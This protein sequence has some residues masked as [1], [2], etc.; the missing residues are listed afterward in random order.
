MVLLSLG[1]QALIALLQTGCTSTAGD[2][3]HPAAPDLSWLLYG[4]ESVMRLPAD[5][6]GAYDFSPT[7]QSPK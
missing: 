2:R 6:G 5:E 7:L 4:P 3:P 1:P